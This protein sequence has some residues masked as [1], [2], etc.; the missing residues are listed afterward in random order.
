M[1]TQH[2]GT[3]RFQSLLAHRATAQPLAIARAPGRVNLI[4]D[5][6]DYCGGPVLPIAI[7]L[8]CH[9]AIIPGAAP[10]G[11][12]RIA[13]TGR[14]DT[15]TAPTDRPLEPG[16]DAPV[17]SW[18]SYA[19]G[20]LAEVQALADLA[21]LSGCE[22]LVHTDIPIGAGLSSSAALEVSVAI[23]SA[24]VLGLTLEGL[25]LA[26]RCRRAEHRFAGMPC[27][28]MDQAASVL[29]RAGHALL[30]D[31]ADETSRHVPVPPGAALLVIDSG[32]KHELAT[33]AYAERWAMCVSASER[34]GVEHLAR[35]DPDAID[36]LPERLRP[37][38]RHVVTESR[39]V[40][41]ASEALE[42]DDLPRA[43]RLMLAS[44]ASLRDDFRV[45]CP[46]IDALVDRLRTAHGVHGLRMTGGGFGGSVVLLAQRGSE[47]SVWAAASECRDICPELALFDA[48]PSE[49]ACFVSR[50]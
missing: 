8:S 27:G 13:S 21:P 45:S 44:H 26:R 14:K 36:A 10:P 16:R 25:D 28:L 4:G 33:G 41:E 34:L 38:A 23:A 37:I 18:A 43:G 12:L 39:R 15:A 30:L 6:V 50:E 46:E 48:P 49:G 32:V 1:T 40:R 22:L 35:A 2:T 24:A 17:G 9:A 20:A 5:H 47:Q 19:L 31:C 11:T 7:P 3:E 42:R 29:A